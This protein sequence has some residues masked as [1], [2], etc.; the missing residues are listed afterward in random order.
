MAGSLA[1]EK[2]KKIL[3]VPFYSQHMDVKDPAWK[4]RACGA[5]AL[6]MVLDYL[7]VETPTPDEF[8][9][10]GIAMGAHGQWGWVHA[11]L[12]ALASSFGVTL[13]RKEFRSQDD[14]EAQE[15]L[16]EGVRELIASLE[17]DKPVLISAIKKW[18]EEKKFHMMVLVGFET[19]EG[20]LKG[21]Y[22]HDPDTFTPEE[23][24]NQFVPI[25]T[26]KKYWRRMA[27]F[28]PS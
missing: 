15:L 1:H 4:E 25:E 26:F 11:G 20:V 21:F 17:H 19:D 8:I 12:V 24:K 10:H 18:I 23:G 7:G 13:E 5:I 16:V 6:Q 9:K 27:I 3:E 22:Y 2:M 14:H 28:I